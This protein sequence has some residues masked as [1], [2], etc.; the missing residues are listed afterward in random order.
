MFLSPTDMQ[1]IEARVAAIEKAH[2]VEVVTVVV[3]K[4]DVYPEI[5]WKAFAL[6]A[7]LTALAV[8]VAEA[9][10]PDWLS[11][12]AVLSAVLAILG[13]G[14]LCALA[15]IYVPAFARLFLRK[16]R[17]ALEVRQFANVQFL[18]RELFGT[19][20]RT[21]ILVVVSMLE[22]RVVIL[23]DTGLHAHAG[24]ADWDAVIARMTPLLGRGRTGEAL[25][26]GLAAIG[27]FLAGKN[28]A[29]GPGNAFAD[30][31]IEEA[32]P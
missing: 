32:G 2:G 3:G 15:S 14:A 21:A 4:S 27:E 1:A 17:A 13:V 18:E 30:K 22:R 29:R 24:V 6:G 28:I 8:T 20:T 5:V 26:A 7:S 10:R 19:A 31:P 23:A 25:Q 11:A 9:A 16:S 12:S